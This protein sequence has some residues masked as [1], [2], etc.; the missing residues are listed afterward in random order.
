M[1]TKSL[2]I[3][4]IAGLFLLAFTSCDKHV[5]NAKI[6]VAEKTISHLENHY[7]DMTPSEFDETYEFCENMLEDI[8]DSKK[9]LTKNQK[10]RARELNWCLIKT[11]LKYD[12]LTYGL[13]RPIEKLLSEQIGTTTKDIMVSN[14]A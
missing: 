5:T 9:G 1:K 2:L 6:K 4:V 8:A 3:T 11:G 14:R 13:K 10:Q 12:F 7:R